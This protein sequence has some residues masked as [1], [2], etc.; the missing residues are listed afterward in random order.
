MVYPVHCRVNSNT[1]NHFNRPIIKPCGRILFIL[2]QI[3]NLIWIALTSVK[4]EWTILNLLIIKPRLLASSVLTAYQTSINLT[5]TVQRKLLHLK[6]FVWT[7]PVSFWSTFETVIRQPVHQ[8]L[9]MARNLKGYLIATQTSRGQGV[10]C[11]QIRD[12]L[13]I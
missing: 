8:L 7:W 3:S 4:S 10:Y 9:L 5:N 11:S 1:N 12:A 2:I 13:P 6:S